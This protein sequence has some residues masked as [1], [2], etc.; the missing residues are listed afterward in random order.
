[1]GSKKVPTHCTRT[2]KVKNSTKEAG[3]LL[4]G[5]PGDLKVVK[6]LCSVQTVRTMDSLSKTAMF[7]LFNDILTYVDERSVQTE[8][9]IAT[10][11]FTAV[12]SVFRSRKNSVRAKA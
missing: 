5:C 11:H 6:V 8:K 12:V 2:T 9:N 4:F 1:M 7:P 10:E 3:Q